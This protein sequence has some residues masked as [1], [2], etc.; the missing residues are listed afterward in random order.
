VEPVERERQAEARRRPRTLLLAQGAYFL[1]TGLWP[2]LDRRS[3]EA[4][5]GPKTD[6]WLVRAVGVLITVIGAALLTAG[7]R[8]NPALEVCLL[9][10][11]SAAGFIAVDVNYTARG[12]I[13]PVYLLDAL[14]EAGLLGLWLRRLRRSASA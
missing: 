12:R 11:G 5:T 1:V 4:V 10:M 7:I 13:S 14:V 8:R 6:F 9:A 2:I 3:F